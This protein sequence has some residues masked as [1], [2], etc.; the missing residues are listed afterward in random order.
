MGGKFNYKTQQAVKDLEQEQQRLT[1]KKASLE[2]KKQELIDEREAQV[3]KGV[4]A[5]VE[6]PEIRPYVNSDGSLKKNL[7]K[8]ELDSALKRVEEQL[9]KFA[10]PQNPGVFRQ[11][12]DEENKIVETLKTLQTKLDNILAPLNP[13][14]PNSPPNNP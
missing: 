4:M 11:L 10:D 3:K 8:I 6:I 12:N 7:S 1:D 14:P 5:K 9:N 13:N 2:A